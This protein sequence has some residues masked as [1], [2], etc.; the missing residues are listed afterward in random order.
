MAN[1]RIVTTNLDFDAIKT[2]LKNFMQGQSQF[3]DYDFEGSSLSLLLDV[4]A[5]NTHYNALHT[6]LAINESFIDSAAKRSSVVSIAKEL[7]YV[8]SS[9]TCSTATIDLIIANPV[10]TDQLLE[11]PKYSL[12]TS[13]SNNITYNFYTTDTYFAYKDNTSN[14]FVF[15][16]IVVKEGTPL[17]FQYP[18][19][20]TS[21]FII[22]NQNVDLKTLKVSVQ[23]NNSS[24]VYNAYTRA[25]NLLDITDT[26]QVYFV[27]EIEG[28]LYQIEFGNGVVGKALESGNV[29]NIEY[30]TC[31]LAAPNGV[32]AFTYQGASL[33]SGTP[34][35][36]TKI[37]ATGGANV[38]DIDSI[39]WNAPRA[40][41]T[42]NRCVTL[43]D[44]KSVIYNYYPNAQTVNVWGGETNVPKTYGDVY[45]SVKPKDKDYL[46]TI[47]KQHLLTDIIGP[48]KAVTIHAKMVDAEYID[49]ALDVTYYYDPKATTR[50]VYDINTLVKNTVVDYN[51]IHLVRF[52]GIFKYSQLLRDVVDT[53]KSISSA[54][55]TVKL[56]RDII[57]SF[58]S[59]PDYTVNLGNPIY[60]SGVPEESIRSN[61]LNVY[62]QPNVCYI[63]DLP[64][65][66]SN[67]GALRLFYY[68]NNVKKLVK[69]IGTV[70]YATGLMSISN[71]ILTGTVEGTFTLTVKP[72]S[73]D[74]VSARQQIVYIR[75]YLTN[76]SAVVDTSAD[77]YKFTSSRN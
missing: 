27:K 19:N 25:E 23:E 31:N 61:G 53:E 67:T 77:T 35:V 70:N 49:V 16:D 51:N 45:I 76:V 73:N 2:N 4:L 22:P 46:T 63:D 11:L 12:F 64:I 36:F 75:D 5:Y 59:A 56:K 20:S 41:T 66:G 3:Q 13:T 39:R 33:F 50:S 47:E 21:Q 18:V 44:F 6:N 65:Q 9:A 54:I 14:K 57:P 69:Y 38:E 40:Y 68:V 10:G 26:T 24:T 15:S 52:D 60:N 8:P 7:G 42:Q 32:R 74:I 37:A 62:A 55:I 58:N 29:V 30:L 34:T 72:Q 28:Q 71:L 48:R 1:Q 17:T 43:D